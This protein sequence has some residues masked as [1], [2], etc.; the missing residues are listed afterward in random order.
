MGLPKYFSPL[1]KKKGEKPH[2]T[3]IKCSWVD[4][5]E[6]IPRNAKGLEKRLENNDCIIPAIR[7][8]IHLSLNYISKWLKLYKT[9][10]QRFTGSLRLENSSI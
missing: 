7:L 9:Y 5:I 6:K 4:G 10:S 8:A 1:K 2:V 3:I